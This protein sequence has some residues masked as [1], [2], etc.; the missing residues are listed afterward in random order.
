[1]LDLAGPMHTGAAP[2][3]AAMQFD[4]RGL[5]IT[6]AD[7]AAAR[8]FDQAVTAFLRHGADAPDYL[9][10]ALQRDGGLVM[11]HAAKALWTLLLARRGLFETASDALAS[12]RRH[13]AQRGGTPRER[14]FV[15]A[16]G[17]ALAD[18]FPAAA[19][20]LEASLD[21]DP[22][23]PLA[24]K[25]SHMLR[26]MIGDAG[27]MRRVTQALARSWTPDVPG[28]GYLLGC[29]AF[30][31]EETGAAID[32]EATGRRAVEHEAED[33]WGFHAVA[34]V[35]EVTGRPGEGVDW[36]TRHEP[37]LAR[38][39]NFAFHVHWH[40]ALFHLTLGD[41]DRV[42]ALYDDKVRA[43]ST[44]DFRDI[45]NAASLLWRLRALGVAVGNRWQELADLA[46]C[47]I[48]DHSLCFADGHY[49]LCLV[50]AGRQ[51]PAERFVRTAADQHRARE[52][53]GHQSWVWRSVGHR[54]AE[55][56]LAFGRG[57]HGGVLAAMSAI[58]AQVHRL[59]GSNVQRDVFEL[60][61][62][63]AAVKGGD[64]RLAAALLD[65]RRRRRGCDAFA[66]AWHLPPVNEPT[67]PYM[68]AGI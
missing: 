3:G 68:A 52:G 33:A 24:M 39:N 22:Y 43:Q 36:L 20:T 50:G 19:A 46:E 7:P 59:G 42:L 60:L 51:G 25:V 17:Q 53:A 62:V 31:L 29:H 26:F 14:S 41:T 12:A 40:K 13:L 55:A 38:S 8:A 61:M 4:C 56:I 16:A 44:D 64:R 10:Q 48:G 30:A 23:D 21:R 54:V 15:Q 28:Y 5:A 34:H 35:L 18:D 37:A 32:A 66:Q 45:A 63:E 6:T 27:G 1:M 47:H 9:G 58:R 2:S 65:G 11:A 49:L 67:E 57:D